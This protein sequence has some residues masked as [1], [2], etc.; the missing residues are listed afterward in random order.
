MA[1]GTVVNIKWDPVTNGK[2]YLV[3]YRKVDAVDWIEYFNYTGTTEKVAVIDVL[4]P[5][6]YE[7]R[8]IALDWEDMATVSSV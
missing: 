5:G 1:D 4:N 3:E 8:V 6:P 2:D 7:F